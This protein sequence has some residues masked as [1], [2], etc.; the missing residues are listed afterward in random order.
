MMT[1]LPTPPSTTATAG[2]ELA[3]DL[4]LAV[5]RLS[6]RLRQH[7][8]GGLSPSQVSALASL[9][10]HG[11][12]PMGRLSRL[13][14]VSAPTMTRIVDRL[15]LQGLVTRRADPGDARSAV[16]ELTDEG[17]GSLARLR[18]ERTAF[19]AQRLSG[20]DAADRAAVT[21]ALPALRRLAD[22]RRGGTEER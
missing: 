20:L 8:V 10:R 18:H 19:L 16:V 4:R 9:D 12:V 22:D 6:R 17:A 5:S 14:G 2:D 21:A 1:A 13:E 3:A 7:A 11:P 15:E